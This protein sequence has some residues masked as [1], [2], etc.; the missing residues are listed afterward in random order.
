MAGLL[1]FWSRRGSELRRKGWLS[2]GAVLSCLALACWL[3]A[4]MFVYAQEPIVQ[5]G[6]VSTPTATPLALPTA[7]PI[8]QAVL[9]PAVSTELTPAIGSDLGPHLD[10]PAVSPVGSTA[11]VVG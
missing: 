9:G 3:A 11:R 6:D 2:R 1:W 7:T 10:V 4:G 8:P 5:P